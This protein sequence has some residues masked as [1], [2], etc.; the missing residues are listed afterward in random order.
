MAES[1][2]G[3]AERTITLNV[4]SEL[5][6]IEWIL[7]TE[8][9]RANSKIQLFL[10]TQSTEDILTGRS[11]VRAAAPADEGSKSES[12]CATTQSQPMGAD[13]VM[14]P[15]LTPGNARLVSAQ[16]QL[17]CFSVSCWT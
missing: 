17:T 14:A 13:H 6:D 11:G 16:V 9:D 2:A 4:Q 1:E 15:V 8:I 10:T 7:N 3:V 12:G 5:C